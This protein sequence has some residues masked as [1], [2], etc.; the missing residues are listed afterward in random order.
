MKNGKGKISNKKLVF[1]HHNSPENNI[2]ESLYNLYKQNRIDGLNVYVGNI[3]RTAQKKHLSIVL[4][5]VLTYFIWQLITYFKGG[6]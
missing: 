4:S 6:Y 1:R 3:L 2:N 5:G